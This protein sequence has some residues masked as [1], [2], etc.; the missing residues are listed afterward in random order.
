MYCNV[1]CGTMQLLLVALLCI[2]V[3]SAQPITSV[4]GMATAPG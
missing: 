4:W 1:Q 3:F 2:N